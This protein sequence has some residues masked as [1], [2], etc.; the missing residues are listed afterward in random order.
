[1]LK[2][3][4]IEFEKLEIAHEKQRVQ[5]VSLGED[6]YCY[7]LCASYSYEI[8]D[9][10]QLE[11]MLGRCIMVFMLQIFLVYFYFLF[12]TTYNQ[13]CNYIYRPEVD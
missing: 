9:A 11:S 5:F 4:K 3:T 2:K 8:F 12:M 13:E 6:L 1:M 7:T 10:N